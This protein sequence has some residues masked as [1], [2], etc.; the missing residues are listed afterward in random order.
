MSWSYR[1]ERVGQKEGVEKQTGY[2]KSRYIS[3]GSICE[4]ETQVLLLG[5][6][7]DVNKESVRVFKDDAEEVE[8]VLK[9]RIE[10]HFTNLS[11][12]LM[13]PHLL[14]CRGLALP[15]QVGRFAPNASDLG[16]PQLSL[17]WGSIITCQR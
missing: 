16:Y 7:N 5:N 10:S 9:A 2:L 11:G 12:K 4:L 6:L 17:N 13:I 3:Y 15:L 14:C 8:K 1:L